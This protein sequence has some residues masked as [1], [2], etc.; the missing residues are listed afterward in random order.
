MFAN[1]TDNGESSRRCHLM[2]FPLRIFTH[3]DKKMT[4]LSFLIIHKNQFIT[5]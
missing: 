5:R 3:H 4:S 2:H 1:R